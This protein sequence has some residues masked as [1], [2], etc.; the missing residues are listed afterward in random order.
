MAESHPAWAV[1]TCAS[2]CAAA[3][4][5]VL[6][7]ARGKGGG[8]GGGAGGGAK[9][10]GGGSEAQDEA[11]CGRRGAY[12][13]FRR[14]YLA[15][16][17]CVMLADWLQGTHMYTLYQAYGMD[18]GTLFLT[19]F[20]SAAV[21]GTVVGALADRFGRKNACV[22]YCVLEIVINA[23]EHVRDLR[24]LLLGRVL[25]GVSTNLLFTCFESWM[26]TRHR[27]LGFPEA[28][29]EDTFSLM[30]AG[31]GIC[32]IVAGVVAQAA[33][34]RLGDIGPFQAAIV[35]TAL[36]LLLVLPWPEN[37]A[38][39]RRE[40]GGEEAA[41]ASS[42][43]RAWAAARADRA[44]V[45]LGLSQA[46]FDGATFTFVFVWVPTLQAIAPGGALPTGLVFS[47]FMAA[48][49]LG[50]ALVAPAQRAFGAHATTAAVL[51]LAA[52]A[53]AVPALL[54]GAFGAVLCAMLAFEGCVGASNGCAG[55]LRSAV[56][57]GDCHATLM[58]LFRVPLNAL[59]VTGTKLADV[60]PPSTVF[61]VCAAWHL[62]SLALHL[63]LADAKALKKKAA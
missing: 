9:S 31:N 1:A 17:L 62:V 6:A 4:V 34:D 7:D 49:T 32:A 46:V 2:L 20:V 10:G 37:R 57:P 47:S 23:L 12:E 30:A 14:R 16:Y 40:E 55:T 51:A 50:G 36:A 11:R 58:N 5:V 56:L 26:V 35:L 60:Y 13:A 22:L 39:P 41:G 61:A 15:A 27:E 33:A 24:V 3:A 53:N 48:I 18:V 63:P 19:G 8:G 38:A 43:A 42:L 54:P 21:F 28:W 25:G 59:V 52:A 29:L 44:V 45:L